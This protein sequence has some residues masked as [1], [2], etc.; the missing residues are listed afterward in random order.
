M[1][2]SENGTSSQGQGGNIYV[3]VLDP[4]NPNAK[5]TIHQ[6]GK[7]DSKDINI[8]IYLNSTAK[9]GNTAT[10][11]ISGENNTLFLNDQNN[12]NNNVWKTS[13]NKAGVIDLSIYGKPASSDNN[14]GISSNYIDK[15]IELTENINISGQPIKNVSN[16]YNNKIESGNSFGINSANNFTGFSN[17]SNTDSNNLKNSGNYA[18]SG[19][20]VFGQNVISET[21]SNGNKTATNN[22]KNIIG[23]A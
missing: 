1:G 4:N 10:N 9:D 3:N 15:T 17:G 13:L 7:N 2:N 11:S 16:S 5:N 12:P 20:I 6:T 14:K 18:L 8:A 19:S 23:I 22:P 21:I